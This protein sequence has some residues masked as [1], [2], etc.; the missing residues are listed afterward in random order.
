MTDIKE[1]ALRVATETLE[2]EDSFESGSKYA[3]G[4]D[5]LTDFATRFLA[6]Y[7]AEQEPVA[8]ILGSDPFDER[9]GVRFGI[10]D[11]M[12]LSK[13]P[14]GTKLFTAPPEPAPQQKYDAERYRWIA[15]NHDCPFAETDEAWESKEKL[16][17]AIDAAR[18]T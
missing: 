3:V 1:L 7:L 8:T 14:K 4:D 2:L 18:S 6:A 12:K 9:E 10:G 11:L 16:D 17:A 5:E 13:L 15:S